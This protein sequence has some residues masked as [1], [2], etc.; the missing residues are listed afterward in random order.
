MPATFRIHPA[1]GVARLGNSPT[2]YYIAPEKTGGLPIECDQ[3][4]GNAIVVNGV[5]QHVSSFKENGQIRR[6]AA[7]FRVFVYD[8]TADG[9]EL[10]IG[11][12][13]TVRSSSPHARRPAQTLKVKVVDVSWTVYVANKKASW[14]EFL[15]TSGEHG[16]APNHPLRNADI[17]DA[18]DRQQLIIDPGP[19]SV[20]FYDQYQGASQRTASFSA[21]P[22]SGQTFPPP[23]QPNSITTLGEIRSTQQDGANRLL[24]LGGL[25]NSGSMKTGFGNPKIETFANN[26]GWFDDISDGPVT[27]NILYELLEESGVPVPPN[28]QGHQPRG[29]I[30]VDDPAWV[31]VGYPRYAPEVVDI[32]TMDD[33]LFDLSV[34]NFAYVPYLFGIAPFDGSVPVPHSP[35]EMQAWRSRATFNPDYY[36][37]FERDIWPILSRPFNYQFLMDADAM[38]GGDPHQTGPGGNFDKG[39]LRVP[40]QRGGGEDPGWH[41]RQFLYAALR[42]P[43]QEND[44]FAQPNRE[45]ND[46]RYSIY[47]AMPRLCG[48]NPLADLDDTAPP[49]KF[50]RL[51]DTMLFMLKQW[52]EGKFIDEKQE[53]IVAPAEPGGAGAALDRGV[54]GSVLGG[55]FCPGAETSWI[56]RNPAIYAAPYRINQAGYTPGALSQPAVVSGATTTANLQGGLEP[57]DISKYDAIP[58]QADFNEC[59][60]QDI[61]ITY[62]DWNVRYPDSTGDVQP[63]QV[64]TIYWWPAHRPMYVNGAPWSPT[65]VTPAGDLQMVTVWSTLGFVTRNPEFAV[66]FSG[67]VDP[68]DPVFILTETS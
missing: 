24:V 7:R 27:A 40:P 68:A 55:S 45:L 10:R 66:G 57:G 41:K 36:P 15:Q 65:A 51:T 35:D 26:D 32:V 63:A 29:S 38:S 42:K 60:T 11:D 19:Q 4:T 59:A 12:V 9:R 33:L 8:G 20:Q 13:L 17:T 31:I 48:D 18:Q 39:V 44:P 58:W 56:V 47:F 22:N 23:L 1:I 67:V 16:Y 64:E 28:K 37:Y 21:S 53:G 43:G 52:A 3:D 6:Q 34:R 54:L 5:E 61:D 30:A 2:S 49:S 62:S 50:L 46:P 25:G 14:Y